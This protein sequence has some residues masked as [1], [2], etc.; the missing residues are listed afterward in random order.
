MKRLIYPVILLVLVSITGCSEDVNKKAEIDV[1]YV[2]TGV[3][4]NAWVRIPAGKFYTDRYLNEGE[5]E[6]DYEIMLTHVT[7]QQFANYLNEALP[8]KKIKLENDSIWGYYPGDKFRAYR[9]E[10]PV[11][12]GDK[13]HL[14]L[15]Q[16]GLRVK[17]DG[18]KFFVQNGFQNH[19]VVFVTW[20]GAKEYT[21][22]YGW[23]LPTEWEWTKAA[24][25][26]D[27]RAY[28]WGDEITRN[29][30]NFYS[31]RDPYEKIFGKQGGTT[32][33]GYY[34]GKTYD[35]YQTT[36]SRSPYG[37]YDMSGNVWHWLGT[38]YPDMHYRWMRGGSFENY[39]FDT[40]IWATN[41][42]EPQHGGL[43]VGFRC[44]RDVVEVKTQTGDRS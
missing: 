13:L 8:T 29:Q 12:A 33:V 41:N 20:F 3:N 6:K 34:N 26:E 19:P 16:P 32:P 28:P 21:D 10:L 22:F 39:D 1:H 11:E 5:I 25:G 37:L 36:D 9:H 38:V 42:A 27:K 7:N 15:N 2:D 17:Y 4:P 30:A 18:Q 24:R 14:K 44:A 40:R 23:R 31:S 35:G 43:N